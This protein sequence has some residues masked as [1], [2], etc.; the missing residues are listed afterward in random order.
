MVQLTFLEGFL[1]QGLSVWPS[2]A[3]LELA[4][5]T[6]LASQVLGLKIFATTPA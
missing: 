3:D 2:L 4:L 6:K 1:K 5:K